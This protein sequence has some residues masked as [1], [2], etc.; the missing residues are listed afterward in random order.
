MR[1]SPA[2]WVGGLG[3]LTGI[4][5]LAGSCYQAVMERR[6]REWSKPAGELIDVDGHRI[7]LVCDGARET[8]P[9]VVFE[10]GMTCPLQEWEWIAPR[11]A[12]HTGTVRYDRP[13]NGFS[14]P[15]PHPRTAD[16]MA[17]ELE[18]VLERARVPGPYILVGHS[19]GG[20]LVRHFAHRNP[21]RTAGVVLVDA[22]HP[23]E[24]ERSPRQ[25]RGLPW[26]EQTM[27][28][29]WARARLGILR[30]SNMDSPLDQL[31]E[32][33]ATT[34][35]ERMSTPGSWRAALRELRAWRESI[36]Y[37][38]RNLPLPGGCSLSVVTAG[39][40]ISNDP[41]HG[42]LQQD[43][44]ALGA[45][46]AHTV[47]DDADHY[48]L[49]TVPE[50]AERVVRAIESTLSSTGIERSFRETATAGRAHSG[51]K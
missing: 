41:V 22:T 49:V 40:Q 42:R 31:P 47:V 5:A 15:T 32:A 26:L 18:T 44:A 14:D 39:R 17:T 16:R 11:I 25:Q 10:N 34:V 20:L 12:E 24:L 8:G 27:H 1:N 3:L 35:R 29:W 19:F 21:E 36:Q 45:E 7:H 9:T 43:L 13:G 37:E 50:H 38:T 48:T 51:E 33:A 2:A 28:T 30:H 46:S 4:G 6:D 23:E